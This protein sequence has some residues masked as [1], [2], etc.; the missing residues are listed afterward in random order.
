MKGPQAQ[1][2]T[3]L[4]QEHGIKGLP[5]TAEDMGKGLNSSEFWQA[6]GISPVMGG[7]LD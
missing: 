3:E 7:Q 4:M 2:V 6:V 1:W 5:R